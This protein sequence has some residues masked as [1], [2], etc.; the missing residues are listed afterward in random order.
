MADEPRGPRPQGPRPGRPLTGAPS[1]AAFAGHGIQLAI[2]IL[3]CLY[4]GQWLDRKLGTDPLFL[5]VGVFVGAG[6]GIYS[7][8]R[9]LTAAQRERDRERKEREGK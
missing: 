2:S 8:I 4:A 9:A 5:I 1:A 7:M 3:I 6:A